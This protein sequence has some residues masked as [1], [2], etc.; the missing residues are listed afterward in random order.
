LCVFFCVLFISQKQETVDRRLDIWTKF[1]N[2]L[3]IIPINILFLIEKEQIL[4]IVL[5][6]KMLCGFYSSWACLLHVVVIQ[7]VYIVLSGN[8]KAIKNLDLEHR[9]Y[10]LANLRAALSKSNDESRRRRQHHHTG[11]EN[12]KK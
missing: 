12:I 6:P 3:L 1:N 5:P 4:Y 2:S 10:M 8:Q 7:R 11:R 9:E